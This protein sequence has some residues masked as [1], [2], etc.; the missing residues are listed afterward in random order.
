M[1]LV[2]ADRHGEKETE[3]VAV[4]LINVNKVAGLLV[5][6]LAPA[7]MD[8]LANLA[9]NYSVPL[10]T[11]VA[12]GGQSAN[13]YLFRTGLKPAFKGWILARFAFGD[14][15]VKSAGIVSKE[16]TKPPLAGSLAPDIKNAFVAEFTRLG[17]AILGEFTADKVDELPSQIRRAD[18]EKA[19][20]VFLVG[21]P[22][23]LASL[24]Q[25]RISD[26]TPILFGGPDEAILPATQTEQFSSTAYLVTAFSA[27]LD[28]QEAKKFI[29]HYK[30]RFGQTPDVEAALAFEGTNFLLRAVSRSTETEN[31][32]LKEGLTQMKELGG[33]SGPL[34]WE[35]GN[36]AVRNGLV[37][38]YNKNGP[39]LIKRFE[40]AEYAK[41]KEK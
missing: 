9:Q 7:E 37:V 26:A 32:S 35:E 41:S 21:T 15:K 24:A 28:T 4:R 6:G 17:G 30:E 18:R 23:D 29:Q 10:V 16:P 12:F 25:G 3:P 31:W 5:D 13:P 38:R 40:G 14:L 1:T 8:A 36:W 34:R 22:Q 11:S 20:A 2:R 33:L 39:K 19:I 27:D